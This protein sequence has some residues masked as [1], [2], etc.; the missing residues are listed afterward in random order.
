MSEP[1]TSKKS[2]LGAFFGGFGSGAFNGLMMLGIYQVV[3]FAILG[4]F[5][6]GA[7]GILMTAI[8]TGIF[9]GIMSVKRALSSDKHE[10]ATERTP[11]AVPVISQ[12]VGMAPSMDL[13]QS[14]EA[15]TSRGSWAD[16]VG[17]REDNVQKILA[18]GSLS[19]KDRASA[20]LAEREQQS[21]S[22]GMT[23]H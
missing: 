11:A 8:T 14:Q 4:S 13:A 7:V 16:R 9:G 22:Q 23:I 10:S 5:P 17:R 18:N 12:S 2:G 3:G 20:I 21:A 19:D 6:L 15:E 1:T